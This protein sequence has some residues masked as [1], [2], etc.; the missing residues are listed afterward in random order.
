MSDGELDLEAMRPGLSM[1]QIAVIKSPARFLRVIAG[2]GSGKTMVLTLRLLTIF[3]DYKLSPKD[4]T[5]ITFTRAAA[6]QLQERVAQ[7]L[8]V[9]DQMKNGTQGS[10]TDAAQK[11]MRESLKMWIGTIHAWCLRF[12]REHGRALGLK[13]NFTVLDELDRSDIRGVLR[14]KF[15]EAN[16][17]ELYWQHKMGINALDYNDLIKLTLRIFDEHPQVKERVHV[18][19]LFW[20]EFQDS[21]EEDYR[22]LRH[23]SPIACTIVGDPDQAIY[24]FRGS[25]SDWM[26]R[27]AEDYPDTMT[28]QLTNCYRSSP[29]I[30]NAAR[31][32]IEHEEGRLAERPMSGIRKVKHQMPNGAMLCAPMTGTGWEELALLQLGAPGVDPGSV[33]ILVRTN[34]Q[35]ESVTAL[36]NQKGIELSALK[37]PA[38]LW[39]DPGARLLLKLLQH[40]DNPDNTW[41]LEWM[42]GQ[43]FFGV[44][45]EAFAAAKLGALKM[46]APL[47]EVA[48]ALPK[49][50][51]LRQVMEELP[52]DRERPAGDDI[53]ALVKALDPEQFWLSRLQLSRVDAMKLFL[54]YFL[55]KWHTIQLAHARPIHRR[56]LLGWAALREAQDEQA[57]PAYFNRLPTVA[58]M[59]AA[60]GL[61]WDT[62]IVAPFYA[63]E[64]PH[65]KGP[66][67]EE[68]RLVYVALTRARD[69][70]LFIGPPDLRSSGFTKEIWP[71][72]GE[73]K[74][75]AVENL[76]ELLR[77]KLEGN[78]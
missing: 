44:D 4:I 48:R 68:R 42:V 57:L 17:E 46:E 49:F 55:P 9:D 63:G 45:A 61:E 12:L 59:H 76:M 3:N 71:E 7:G 47:W 66:I 78:R 22:L 36:A 8:F 23:L 24:G 18:R 32:L 35:L 11:A 43:G 73:H 75:F 28:L 16:L 60:K 2:P 27:F 69:T 52:F 30:V 41:P 15:G 25:S 65:P 64:I 62:V 39:A 21:S 10:P 38:K 37:P 40:V 1:E 31:R 26:R 53:L 34:R 20:D 19:W 29:L 13:T 5:A 54:D 33:A 58:T 70:A 6:Q 50:S 14:A 56:A 67:D 74:P 72:I 77:A 51:A